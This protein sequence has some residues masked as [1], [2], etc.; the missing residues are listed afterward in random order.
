MQVRTRP[1]SMVEALLQTAFSH[2]FPS[3]FSP[4][5]GSR[6]EANDR[7]EWD[8]SQSS[9]ADNGGSFKRTGWLLWL[10]GSGLGE[11][12]LTLCYICHESD[13]YFSV[14]SILLNEAIVATNC[15][16]RL[17]A[18]RRIYKAAIL[19]YLDFLLQN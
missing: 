7:R 9:L 3:L 1:K 8:D 13:G 19:T 16:S 4:V 15:K 11:C 12:L 2:T 10:V 14:I 5:F 18:C 6:N 17:K